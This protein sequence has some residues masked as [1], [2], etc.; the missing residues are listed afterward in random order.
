MTAKPDNRTQLE[1]FVNIHGT[2]A[3]IEEEAE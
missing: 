3:V 1:K 2:N